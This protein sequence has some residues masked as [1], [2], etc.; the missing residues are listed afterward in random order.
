[1]DTMEL[2]LNSHMEKIPVVP[3]RGGAEVALDLIIKP[4]L[5]IELA[6]AVGRACLLCVNLLHRYCPR[7]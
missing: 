1:M 7:T 4:V 5:S 3:A 6:R 2:Q